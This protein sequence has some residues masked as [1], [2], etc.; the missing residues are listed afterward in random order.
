[1]LFFMRKNKAS[2]CFLGFRDAAVINLK[3][4][5][6]NVEAINRCV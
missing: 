1:M 6:F 2:H 3:T 4:S 5:R